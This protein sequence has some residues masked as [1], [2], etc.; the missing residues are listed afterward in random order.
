MPI[1]PG[2]ASLVLNLNSLSQLFSNCVSDQTVSTCGVPQGSIVGPLL[3]NLFILSLDQLN[4]V[5][6]MIIRFILNL[7]QVNL[8]Q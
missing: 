4:S 1:Y 3:F 8:N 6:Q 7:Q 2:L 5:M